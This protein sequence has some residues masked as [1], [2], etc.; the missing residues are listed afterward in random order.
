M[1]NSQSQSTSTDTFTSVLNKN[2]TN[3]CQTVVNKNSTRCNIQQTID[4]TNLG[5]LSCDGDL[6]I[7]NKAT[8]LCRMDAIFKSQNENDIKN[9]LKTAIDSSL[10]S[11]NKAT[12][13]FLSGIL[14][15]QSQSNIQNIKNE[16]NNIIEN[17]ISQSTINECYSES[18]PDQY[19]K[20]VNNKNIKAKNC[21][22]G[23][24]VQVQVMA[25]CLTDAIIKNAQSNSALSDLTNKT[26]TSS[27]VSQ[28]GLNDLVADFF[29][30]I[31]GVINSAS[32][33]FILVG[34]A[35]ICGVSILV[36]AVLL[37]PAGQDSLKQVTEAGINKYG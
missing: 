29:A 36:G 35:L 18:N 26:V 32:L 34:I 15:D 21:N 31:G 5:N 7:S 8:A 27:D 12:Q 25:T 3:L 17:N 14:T 30:G 22:F 16:L 1:G 10:D 13:G 24:D 28:K 19:I 33:P 11:T 6:T 37:S 20:F 9:I 2:V 23:N 4:F